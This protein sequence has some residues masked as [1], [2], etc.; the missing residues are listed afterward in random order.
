MSNL[1]VLGQ[2]YYEYVNDNNGNGFFYPAGATTTYWFALRG[3]TSPNFTWDTTQG[4]LS[5]Y[6][7]KTDFLNCPSASADYSGF[8]LGTIAYPLTT[9]AYNSTIQ[10][11]TSSISQ[12]SGATKLSQLDKSY[13]TV[14]LIDAITV[15]Y[16]GAVQGCYADAS[17]WN[18]YA[19][20]GGSPQTPHFHGLHSG[21]GNVLWY[22][23]H[24][25]SQAPYM[26]DNPSN[27]IQTSATPAAI[28]IQDKIKVGYLTPLTPANTPDSQLFVNPGTSNL[29][30]Y[31]WAR[32]RLMK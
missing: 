28:A 18:P 27:L 24:V 20:G 16:T 9:Y 15:T 3:G 17:P 4:F 5:K 29:N 1:R 25:S 14:A 7:R 8:L 21:R 10:Y 2:C 26:T 11:S 12:D 32:K 19:T 31:Y 22:D 30:Y 13:D 23:G 6:F